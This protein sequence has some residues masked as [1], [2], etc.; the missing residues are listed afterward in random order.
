VPWIP[1]TKNPNKMSMILRD[2]RQLGWSSAGLSHVVT[3]FL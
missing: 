1:S 3:W 2:R